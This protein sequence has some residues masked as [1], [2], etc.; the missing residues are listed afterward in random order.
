MILELVE[1]F[2][3]P[4][5]AVALTLTAVL[6]PTRP[7]LG[8]VLTRCPRPTNAGSSNTRSAHAR[9]TNAGNCTSSHG[10]PTASTS[11]R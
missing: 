6:D 1:Y 3:A 10:G 4:L 5:L 7:V 9:S 2:V 11:R 8:Q